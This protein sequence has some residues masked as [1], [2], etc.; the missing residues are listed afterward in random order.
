MTTTAP[1]G[2]HDTCPVG[3][4]ASV[5]GDRWSLLIVRDVMDGLHRFGDLQ[6]NLG[7]ARNILADRLKRLVDAGVLAT[8]AAADGS[9]YQQ[10]VLTAKGE[11]L[12]PLIVALR[13]WGE[14]HLF[15]A[16]EPHSVLLEKASGQP[17]APMQ[18]T[19][20]DGQVLQVHHTQVQRPS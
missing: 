3:R 13:Q 19:T 7:A 6:R 5:M 20:A 1:S 11:Q 8:Q 14:Q 12:F 15:A 18:P 2:T 16:N 4:A 9:A 17:I 10:Y